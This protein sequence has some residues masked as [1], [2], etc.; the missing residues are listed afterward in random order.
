MLRGFKLGDTQHINSEC[1]EH[2][3]DDGFTNNN[4]LSPQR[5]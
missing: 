3:S 5:A 1:N 2:I 4:R